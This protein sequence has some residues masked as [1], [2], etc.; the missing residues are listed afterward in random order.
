MTMFSVTDISEL[1]QRIRDLPLQSDKIDEEDVISVESEGSTQPSDYRPWE[2][3][4]DRALLPS[5]KF[6]LIF[7][8]VRTCVHVSHVYTYRMYMYHIHLL[9]RWEVLTYRYYW[10][11]PLLYD[12]FS[13]Y[14]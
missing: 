6:K 12:S 1:E 13:E 3:H 5:C 11:S 8:N 10:P 9:V 4:A 7:V 2:N 14:K